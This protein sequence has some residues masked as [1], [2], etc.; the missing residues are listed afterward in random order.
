MRKNALT[1]HQ[2]V[3]SV[4]YKRRTTDEEADAR[5]KSAAR[6]TRQRNL[7]TSSGANPFAFAAGP[8]PG[9]PLGAAWAD[10]LSAQDLHGALA[11]LHGVHDGGAAAAGPNP[12]EP[13]SGEE[14]FGFG[15]GHGAPP[16]GGWFGAP[17]VG[18][19]FPLHDH[20][21]APAP[22]G[23]GVIGAHAA[24]QPPPFEI[25]GDGAAAG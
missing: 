4:S 1:N 8:L 12:A 10:A 2:L 17:P 3:P 5:A 20:E 9:G 16:E 15:I 13:D 11:Y 21:E 23:L 14:D 7:R 24:P 22:V 6:R 18:D 19:W 25:A